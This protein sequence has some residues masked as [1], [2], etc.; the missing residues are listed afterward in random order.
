MA[1]VV[2]SREGATVSPLA[3]ISGPVSIAKGA[4]VKAGAVIE[5]P[6]IIAEGAVVGPNCWIRPNTVIGAHCKVGQ[7]V[8]IKNSIIM[9][10]ARV[11]H[12][13]YIG[14]SVVGEHA[15]IGCGTITA[16]FRHDGKNH[17]S[18]VK[19]ELVDT[20]RRKIGA[21][22]GDHV[23]TGINTSLYPGRKLWPHT[24]T[25]PGEVVSRD[26]EE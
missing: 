10:G 19:D 18:M 11:P 6:V 3:D 2:D 5:G 16:N 12:L 4:T 22:I 24:S 23:H 7:G 25:L 15:N 1:G 26:K 8:E 17:C 21:I 13:S 9:D 20:G 14:D